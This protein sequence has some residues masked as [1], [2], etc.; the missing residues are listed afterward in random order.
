LTDG[1]QG[2]ATKPNEN[3]LVDVFPKGTVQGK[4]GRYPFTSG[5]AALRGTIED[6]VSKYL[7]IRLV[8]EAIKAQ[9]NKF[10]AGTNRNA[11]TRTE[12]AVVGHR[13]LGFTERDATWRRMRYRAGDD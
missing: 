12:S 9:G 7:K 4:F 10:L 1:H 5:Q 8:D 3:I 2:A 11:T 6:R 13:G